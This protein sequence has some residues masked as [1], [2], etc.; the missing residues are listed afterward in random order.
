[1]IAPK[2]AANGVAQS[3]SHTGVLDFYSGTKKY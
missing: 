2:P 1:M 3:A